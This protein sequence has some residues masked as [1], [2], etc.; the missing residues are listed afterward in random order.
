MT[1]EGKRI[2][3][4]GMGKSGEAV[5]KVA[6]DRGARVTLFEEGSLETPARLAAQETLQAHGVEVV[7]GWHGRL[8]DPEHDLVVTSPGVRRSHPCL[9]DSVANGIPVWGE[10]EF[11]YRIAPCP[12]LGITGTNG[13]STT[14]VMAWLA[15]REQMEDCLLCGNISGSGYPELTLT[16]AAAIAS[17]NSVLVAEISSYQLEWV[18]KFRPRVA[19]ITNVTPDH[20]DRHPDFED[21]Q[22]TKER[23]YACMGEGDTVV[24]NTVSP[25]IRPEKFAH[26][27]SVRVGPGEAL[28]WDGN[29][30]LIRGETVGLPGLDWFGPHTAENAAVALAMAGSFLGEASDLEKLLH[31]IR[32]FHGLEHRMEILGSA[33]GIRVV[34]NSMC[35]NPA[36]LIANTPRDRQGLHLLVGGVMKGLDYAAVR[37]HFANSSHKIYLFGPTLPGTLQEAWREEHES[38]PHLEAA[39]DAAIANAKDGETVMLSP[40]CASAPP[41]ANF[42]ERGQ[43]FKDHATKWLESHQDEGSWTNN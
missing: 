21:Y 17:S 8:T 33:K 29:D 24:W 3:V 26:L 7:A 40:G 23:L 4:I 32:K 15:L 30:L 9:R 39:F 36:A 13:K 22:A 42:R 18:E 34:N 37:S 11:A 5:A 6:A 1:F 35:T 41:H 43:A 28:G 2:A 25:G 27:S 12:I 16:E 14:T 20:L 38:Y 31:G 10:I 19:T